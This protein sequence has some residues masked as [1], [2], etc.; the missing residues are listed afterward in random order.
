MAWA[1]NPSQ[2]PSSWHP[3]NMC[4]QL[5]RSITKGLTA[6]QQDERKQN[7]LFVMLRNCSSS[8]ADVNFKP[9][10]RGHSCLSRNLK[11]QETRFHLEFLKTTRSLMKGITNKNNKRDFYSNITANKLTSLH[12]CFDAVCIFLYSSTCAFLFQLRSLLQ[13]ALIHTLLTQSSPN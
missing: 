1:I 2:Y 5:C 10:I 7:H 11:A 13:L 12:A 6:Q 4:D 3:P 8:L 9:F